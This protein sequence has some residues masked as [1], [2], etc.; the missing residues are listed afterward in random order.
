MAER[1][2][3]ART[4]AGYRLGPALAG[5]FALACD[6]RA[7][8]RVVFRT[9]LHPR[10]GVI[11]MSRRHLGLAICVAVLAACGGSN[12]GRHGC[13]GA[14]RRQRLRRHPRGEV[15]RALGDDLPAGRADAG[16]RE[17]GRAEGL[18]DRRATTGDISGVPKV[19]YGGQGGFGDVIVH[20]V[21][22][23]QRHRVPQLRRGGRKRHARRGRGAREAHARRQGRRRALRPEGDLAPGAQGRRAAATS[24]IAW[25]SARTAS[26]GSPRA[27]GRSSIPRR[28]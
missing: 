27:S 23:Q 1:P 21:I 13:G 2:Q 28:T 7:P 22:R 12:G 14:H 24:A 8:S 9:I 18:Q 17:E 5:T 11:P 10:D 4:A 3:G 16:H 26:S 25:P 19:D 15:Q 6:F 20:P